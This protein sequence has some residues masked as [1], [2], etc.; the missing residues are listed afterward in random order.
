VCDDAVL[1]LWVI[2]PKLFES[3]QVI[4]AWGFDYRSSWVWVKDKI[5]L[6][7]YARNQHELL[8]VAKRGNMPL[9]EPQ[10]RAPRR[11]RRR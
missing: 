2:S 10:R 5:G 11:C 7:F 6:G 4:E 8:L 1:F 3:Q 9:P